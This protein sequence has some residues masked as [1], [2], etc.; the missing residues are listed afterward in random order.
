MGGGV[1]LTTVQGRDYWRVKMAWPD[2]APRL[3]GKFASQAEAEKWI[4]EHRWLTEQR[5]VA[6]ETTRRDTRPSWPRTA[7]TRAAGSGGHS[8]T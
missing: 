3:F 2:H 5:K 7:L 6:D 8:G 4:A 1:T